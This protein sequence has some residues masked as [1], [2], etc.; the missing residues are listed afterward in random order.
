MP[1]ESMRIDS[2]YD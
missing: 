2:L 1:G